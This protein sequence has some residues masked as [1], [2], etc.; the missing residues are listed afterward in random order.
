MPSNTPATR[1]LNPRCNAAVGRDGRCLREETRRRGGE[2]KAKGEART[3]RSTVAEVEAV[4][5]LVFVEAE[6]REGEGA[7]QEENN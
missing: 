2:G 1:K 3:S 4:E 7:E 6:E 5:S